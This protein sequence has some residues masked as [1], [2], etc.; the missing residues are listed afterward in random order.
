MVDEGTDVC[1]ESRI[2]SLH[3]IYIYIYDAELDILYRSAAKE[4]PSSK[5]RLYFWPNSLY[6]VKGYLNKR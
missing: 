4:R 5:E 2:Q 6:R 3:I 1:F